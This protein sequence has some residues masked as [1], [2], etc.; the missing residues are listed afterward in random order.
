[1]RKA[2]GLALLNSQA[3]SLALASRKDRLPGYDLDE[4]LSH[5]TNRLYKQPILVSVTKLSRNLT[6]PNRTTDGNR[7]PPQA[8]N[9]SVTFAPTNCSGRPEA[10]DSRCRR[11]FGYEHGLKLLALAETRRSTRAR[12]KGLSKD[13]H[14]CSDRRQNRITIRGIRQ[15]FSRAWTV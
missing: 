13:L 6:R 14:G 3:C 11:R 12:Q 1:M 9:M 7:W 10:C 15:I 2:R 8:R 4:N 5:V